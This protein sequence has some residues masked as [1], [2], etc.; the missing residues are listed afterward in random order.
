MD[1]S[2]GADRLHNAFGVFS[3]GSPGDEIGRDD[4][5]VD[6]LR[7]LMEDAP[8]EAIKKDIQRIVDKMEQM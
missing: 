7:E 5:M 4:G 3:E 1:V 2:A 6:E 8:N